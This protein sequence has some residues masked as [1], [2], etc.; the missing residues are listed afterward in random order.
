MV[1]RPANGV[2]GVLLIATLPGL[3]IFSCVV[4]VLLALARGFYAA[5]RAAALVLGLF[6]VAS[7]LSGT[8]PVN[9]VLSM[10][11][12]WLPCLVMVGV[13]ER[14]RSMALTVQLSVI[15]GC[16]GLAGFALLIDD[17]LT[18]WQPLIDFYV[19]F[20]REAG[21]VELANRVEQDLPAVA[22]GLTLVMAVSYWLL[23]FLM[24]QIGHS[25]YRLLPGETV[26]Y[27]RFADLSLGKV[28]AVAT[29]VAS[30]G[31]YLLN[32]S[33][34]DG[35]AVFLFTAFLVQGFAV[36]HWHRRENA[37]PLFAVVLAYVLLMALSFVWGSILALVGYLDAWFGLRKKIRTPA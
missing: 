29:A 23:L 15:V 10:A 32:Q 14:T 20:W 17:P 33:W 37:L 9:V 7:F 34:L 28:L 22:N 35:A 5:L 6:V 4:L 30:A 3:G 27:G 21:Q 19:N 2:L 31:A 13:L 1:E 18:V 26:N 16:A 24:I 8:S 12:N 11:S 25:W 36:V